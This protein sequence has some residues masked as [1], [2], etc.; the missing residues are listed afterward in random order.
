[1][2]NPTTNPS[3][4]FECLFPINTAGPQHWVINAALNWLDRWVRESM[5]PPSAPRLEVV[6]PGFPVEFAV[7]EHGNVLGGIRT[8][9]VDVSIARLNGAGNGPAPGAPPISVFCGAFGVTEP[10]SDEKLA[11]LYPNHGS[12]VRQYSRAKQRAVESG[13]LLQEDADAL[14]ETAAESDIGK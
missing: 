5:P 13:F 3:P 6:T 14:H 2:Q 4:N 7:D 10:F 11:E 9:Y 12:F 8:P 1:M